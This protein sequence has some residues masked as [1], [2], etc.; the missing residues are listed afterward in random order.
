MVLSFDF[1]R[2]R[3]W[4]F[5]VLIYTVL[6]VGIITSVYT[7]ITVHSINKKDL[8]DRVN[9]I[10]QSIKANEIESLSASSL[11]LENPIYIEIKD[12][13][14]KVRG[15][16]SDIRFIYL[17][18]LNEQGMFFYMDS[19]SPD[20]DFYSPPGEPYPEATPLMHQ[21]FQTKESGFEIAA[22]RWGLW[23][24]VYVPII[25][26]ET[27]R[28]VALLGMDVMGLIYILNFLTYSIL[29]SLLTLMIIAMLVILKKRFDREQ[30]YID[31]KAEF[32]SIAS[33]E[34]RTPLTGIRWATETIINNNS[35]IL[36]SDR[37]RTL[38]LIHEN[39]VGLIN[40]INN[41]LSVTVLEGRKSQEVF[42]EPVYIKSLI[43]EINQSLKLSA[44]ARGVTLVVTDFP[45]DIVIKC[46]QEKIRQVL[47]N[48]ISNA[49]KYTKHNTSVEVSYKLVDDKHEISVVDHGNGID[50]HQQKKIFAGFYRTDEARK[51]EQYGS[52]LGLYLVDRILKLHGGEIKVESTVGEGSKFTLSLKD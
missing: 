41:L 29:P 16:N 46:D 18:G 21:L 42:R 43:D 8:I 4:I 13:I 35:D 26:Q 12:L 33:H 37:K 20:S 2:K 25:S 24:S 31:Q 23:A 32:L 47:T 9:T 36:D 3:S 7:A 28:V 49:I 48:L 15:V 39:C 34:I 6:I 22:D 27:N 14:T 10:A 30:Y 52:G 17:N 19:E 51:S 5:P 1:A 40:R 38:M 50:V 11:D 44:Y 45:S